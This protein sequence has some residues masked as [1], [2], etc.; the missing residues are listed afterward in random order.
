MRPPL[1]TGKLYP[2]VFRSHRVRL[3]IIQGLCRPL[4]TSCHYAS[5]AL[6]RA[7][8]CP[9]NSENLDSPIQCTEYTLQRSAGTDGGCRPAGFP[10]AADKSIYQYKTSAVLPFYKAF[11]LGE[12]EKSDSRASVTAAT[13]N[14]MLQIPPQGQ[15]ILVEQD[16][17]VSERN[18]GIPTA[19]RARIRQ[20]AVASHAGEDLDIETGRQRLQYLYYSLFGLLVVTVIMLVL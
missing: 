14:L 7:F 19:W 17:R 13:V 3:M 18:P 20:V 8:C 6:A 16:K 2:Y 11:T 4:N 9:Q 12:I 5:D 1:A 15:V 10:C